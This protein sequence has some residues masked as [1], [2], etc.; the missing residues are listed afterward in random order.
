MN[1]LHPTCSIHKYAACMM[2]PAP[3]VKSRLPPRRRRAAPQQAQDRAS[4]ILAR[5]RENRARDGP[6]VGKD[7]LPF[8]AGADGHEFRADAKRHQMRC[9]Y[10][11]DLAKNAT[12]AGDVER[13]RRFADIGHAHNVKAQQLEGLVRKLLYRD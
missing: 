13:A 3:S 6:G 2:Q 7:A 9:K 11:F 5:L 10:F 12:D 8:R 4:E 1:V